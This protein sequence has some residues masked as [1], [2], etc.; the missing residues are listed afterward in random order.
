MNVWQNAVL[1][2]AHF[3]VTIEGAVALARQG[4]KSLQPLLLIHL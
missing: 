4:D 2:D 3:R 1:D